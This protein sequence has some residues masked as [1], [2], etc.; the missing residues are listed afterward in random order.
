MLTRL[1][2]RWKNRPAARIARALEAQVTEIW[3]I[4]ALL[5]SI[6][7]T[8]KKSAIPD[9]V[10]SQIKAHD[11]KLTELTDSLKPKE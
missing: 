4:S 3:T 7:A 5:A 8:L 6:D 11:A 9:S 10:L 2:D 1:L